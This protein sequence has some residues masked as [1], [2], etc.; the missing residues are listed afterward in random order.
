[1]DEATSS[2]DAESEAVIQKVIENLKGK[3]TVLI[4]AHRL[5]T[6]INCDK[7]FVLERGRIIEEGSP[8]YLLSNKE[9][10]FYRLY[11]IGA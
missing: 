6:V 3:M 1:L 8:D 5:A 4:I 10:H 9:S 2:L 7:L 11:N